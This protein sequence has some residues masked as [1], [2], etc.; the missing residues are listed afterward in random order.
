M[1]FKGIEIELLQWAWHYLNAA[2][3]V[4]MLAKNVMHIDT[5]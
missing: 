3:I 2:R 5:S 4:R 1:E